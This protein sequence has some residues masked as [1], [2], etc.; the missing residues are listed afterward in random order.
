MADISSDP[1]VTDAP[2]PAYGAPLGGDGA[3][4]AAPART[5]F[6]QVM[7]LVAVDCGVRG[8]GRIHRARPQRRHRDR[9]V[10]R[11]VRLHLRTQRGLRPRARAVGDRP[12]V[13]AWG[14]CWESPSP[15]CWRSYAQDRPIRALAGRRRDRRVRRGAW[16]LRLRHASR[17]VL[18]GSDA[19]LGATGSDRARDRPD[20]RLDPARAHRSMRSPG[21]RSSAAFTIFDFNRLRRSNA[22]RCGDDRG[23]HLPRHLQR[24]PAPAPAVW[25]RTRLATSRAGE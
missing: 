22:G 11:R 8:A 9:G 14:C 24:L 15:R 19:V 18:V 1:R 25:R 6:G 3:I 21:W 7:G 12:A 13:R 5:V 2:A 4:A 16:V 17:S 10:H 23:E 20:L